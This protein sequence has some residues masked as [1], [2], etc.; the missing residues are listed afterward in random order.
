MSSKGVGIKIG[1][2]FGLA[3][4]AGININRISSKSPIS[5]FP[6]T[7]H[8]SSEKTQSPI[9]S[10][11]DDDI[12]NTHQ[13]DDNKDRNKEDFGDFGEIEKLP[14]FSNKIRHLLPEI[15]LPIVDNESS[16]VKADLLLLGTLTFFSALMPNVYHKYG[17]HILYANLYLYVTAPPASDKG[18]LNHCKHI[19]DHFQK[20]FEEEYKAEMAQYKRDYA[21]YK[22]NKNSSDEPIK[23]QKKMILIPGNS[24]STSLFQILDEN[25][26]CGLLFETES[27]TI[28]IAF[29]KDYGNYSDGL[30]NAYH[31]E[32]IGYTRRTNNERVN[33][34][35][36]RLS[37]LLSGTPNQ[38]ISLIPESEN[39]LLSRFMFYYIKNRAKWRRRSERD[40][41][42]DDNYFHELGKKWYTL[43][44]KLNK[45]TPIQF[46]ISESQ[47]EKYDDFYELVYNNCPSLFGVNAE[48]AIARL[49]VATRRMAM[50]LSTIRLIGKELP[51][52]INCEDADIESA[53][54]IGQV[55]LQH[56]IRVYASMPNNYSFLNKTS[57]K[58][59]FY[60]S[61]PSQFDRK[62]YVAIAKQLGIPEGTAEKDIDKM[63]KSGLLLR[64]SHGHYSKP[65]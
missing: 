50:I 34:D 3:Q 26:G 57:L 25:N 63:V 28:T 7:T 41:G 42:L 5:S 43:Y 35:N 46:E 62:T 20:Q 59:T 55:L 48:D 6:S 16:P 58:K 38:V 49:G 18:I 22:E 21:K 11:S 60:N 2:L 31:H 29:K 32:S 52:C 65:A 56:I 1:T 10:I 12:I 19:Y 8:F 23:P 53:M 36:P 64:V 45:S 40:K 24:S 37:I 27:D 47:D 33:V 17:T 9:D 30:R 15:L 44:E 61:L 14:T 4:K 54:I 39:G 13:I 51:P